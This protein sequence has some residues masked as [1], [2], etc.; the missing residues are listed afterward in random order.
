[1][2]AEAG[3]AMPSRHQPMEIF[4]SYAHEDEAH[5]QKLET[6]LGMLKRQGLMPH[7][8]IARSLRVPSGRRPLTLT[9]ITLL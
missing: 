4:C 6:H 7:G 8:M 1:M 2:K 3:P 5:L 9:S